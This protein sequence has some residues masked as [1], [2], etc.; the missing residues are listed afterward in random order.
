MNIHQ[1][2]TS[3]FVTSTKNKYL[4]NVLS[5][6]ASV[7]AISLLAQISIPLHFTPV[8]V[9]GQTFGVAVTALML[10]RNRA[11]A[12]VL[13]Y[14]FVGFIGL[15]VFAMAQSGLRFGPT[16][17]YL[18]GMLLASYLMG[19]LA[20]KGFTSSFAKA[21]LSAFFG[22]VV[23]FSLGLYGL[24]FFVAQKDILM[25]GLYPFL[26]GDAIKTILA[27]LLVSKVNALAH[28]NK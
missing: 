7:V 15:P 13:S 19:H 8:P 18:A 23:T 24:S 14:F 11:V 10:G 1:S 9:T 27:A 2:L 6:T 16:S 20:D 26:A 3:Y 17:G 21:W 25:M 5:V 12:A 28:Q 22:S 4:A